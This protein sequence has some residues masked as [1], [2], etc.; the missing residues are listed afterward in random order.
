MLWFDG[1]WLDW[2]KEEDAVAVSDYLHEL[3]PSII[4]NNRL[5]TGRQGM[6]GL[7]KGDKQ[8]VGD[9]G[10]PEQEIPKTGLP[11]VDWEPA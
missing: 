10:T 5:G 7:N 4:I 2:W 8:Y 11:G 3:K 9:F 1:E 6:A